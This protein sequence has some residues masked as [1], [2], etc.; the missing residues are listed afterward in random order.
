MTPGRGTMFRSEA[1]LCST[2]LAHVPD[3][4]TAYPETGEWDILLVHDTGVQIGIEAKLALNAK[5]IVQAAESVNHWSNTVGP[6]FRAVLV[7]SDVSTSFLGI[8]GLLGIT[9]IKAVHPSLFETT[10]RYQIEKR[11]FR[12]E[13]PGKYSFTDEWFDMA[14]IKRHDLP[15]YVPKVTA[16]VPSPMKLSDWKIGAMRLCVLMERS[17]Y[18]CRED[19]Q[20]LGISISRWMPS[21]MKWLGATETRGIYA[22]GKRWPADQFRA[23]HPMTWDEIVFSIDDWAP[24]NRRMPERP[25]LFDGNKEGGD[26]HV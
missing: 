9:V 20:H 10:N 21:S 16:G 25:V 2:F 12:P 23:E 26:E 18:L 22:K 11:W 13:L 17:G 5:V 14:P 7:P 15:D 19:F 24:K 4:W 8:C 1:E 3:G 6:D